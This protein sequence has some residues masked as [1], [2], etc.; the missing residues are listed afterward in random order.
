MQ[1]PPAGRLAGTE[2]EEGVTGGSAETEDG[3]AQRT[4]P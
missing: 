4:V 3:Q 1:E 2:G